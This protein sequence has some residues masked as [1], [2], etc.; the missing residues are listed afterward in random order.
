M[1]QKPLC[2][3]QMNLASLK[4]AYTL[5]IL[6]PHIVHVTYFDYTLSILQNFEKTIGTFCF[7]KVLKNWQ[8]VVKICHGD[9]V[10]YQ[11]V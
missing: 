8:S 1:L 10:R 9:N 6:T 3:N 11:N 2:G 5:D 7:L 4:Y